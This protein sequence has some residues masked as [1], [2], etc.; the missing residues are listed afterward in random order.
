MDGSFFQNMGGLQSSEAQQQVDKAMQV[1]E[2]G[3]APKNEASSE[4]WKA[5]GGCWWIFSRNCVLSLDQ[6]WNGSYFEI[7]EMG[8]SSIGTYWNSGVNSLLGAFWNRVAMSAS[9]GRFRNFDLPWRAVKK[10]AQKGIYGTRKIIRKSL[11]RYPLVICYI[12]IEHGPVEI[13]DNHPLNIF[14]HGDVP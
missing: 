2:P 14:K 6:I 1:W 5:V 13:V 11:G 3:L 4:E 12:A 9:A 7:F 8:G 10:G